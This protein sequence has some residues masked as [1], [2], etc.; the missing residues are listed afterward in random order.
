MIVGFSLY[1][2]VPCLN[3]SV[4]AYGGGNIGAGSVETWECNG[5]GPT[6]SYVRSQFQS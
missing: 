4:R 3:D 2:I 6:L 5:Q 1:F